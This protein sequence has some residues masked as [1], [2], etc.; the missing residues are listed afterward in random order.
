MKHQKNTR[1]NPERELAPGRSGW[2]VKE[3]FPGQTGFGGPTS[4]HCLPDEMRPRHIRVGN[5]IVIIE[6]SREYLERLA[7][8]SKKRPIE[9]RRAA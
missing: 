4:F 9:F 5:R 8:L 3:Y 7:E 2:S 1:T 6:A